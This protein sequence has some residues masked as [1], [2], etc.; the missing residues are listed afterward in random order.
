MRLLKKCSLVL[1]LGLFVYSAGALSQDDDVQT[2]SQELK[3]LESLT[4]YNEQLQLQVN[5]QK[6]VMAQIQESFDKSGDLGRQVVPLMNK[7]VDAITMFVQADLPFRAEER[8]EG[9]ADLKAA[10]IDTETSISEKFRQIMN[11]YAIE[12]EYGRTSEAYSGALSEEFNSIDVDFLR[13]G[14]VALYYQSKDGK[15][16]GMWD[17][18]Q[19]KWVELPAEYNRDI[20]KS[21]RVASKSVAP[22]LIK[23]PVASLGKI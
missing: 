2:F 7:M 19:S 4:A 12:S 5:E 10:M 6:K 18:G 17:K 23:L 9:I 1:T 15:T 3:L 21:I 13:I 16:S 14:R 20:R 8:Q 22:E 11:L